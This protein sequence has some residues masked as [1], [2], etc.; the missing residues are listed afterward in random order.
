MRTFIS[1]FVIVALVGMPCA[2]VAIG[3]GSRDVEAQEALREQD[4]EIDELYA[5]YG[6]WASEFRGIQ[7]ELGNA[8]RADAQYVIDGES[9]TLEKQ[10][11]R[12]ANIKARIRA[13][14]IAMITPQGIRDK[15]T[16]EVTAEVPVE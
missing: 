6:D 2:M 3:L 1:T 7:V 9:L 14:R 12:E 5:L 11:R 4:L 10:E 8:I 13:R 16:A 15:L